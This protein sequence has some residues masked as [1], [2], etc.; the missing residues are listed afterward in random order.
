MEKIE[1]VKKYREETSDF[2]RSLS[3]QPTKYYQYVSPKNNSI[4]IPQ[5]SSERRRYILYLLNICNLISIDLLLLSSMP[6][7]HLTLRLQNGINLHCL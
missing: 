1:N 6:Y 4:I 7:E 2:S 5:A 3:N